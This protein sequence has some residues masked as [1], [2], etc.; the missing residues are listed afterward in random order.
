M[1]SSLENR[2]VETPVNKSMGIWTAVVSCRCTGGA[3]GAGDGGWKEGF[4][5]YI[6]MY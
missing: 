1:I 4:V 6:I 3:G 5:L 2:E